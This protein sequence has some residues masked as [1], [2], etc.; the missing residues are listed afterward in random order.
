M[1]QVATAKATET[2]AST[3]WTTLKPV[4]RL[5]SPTMFQMRVPQTQRVQSEKDRRMMREV[6]LTP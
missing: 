4:D 6:R 5:S 3:M 1:I 2:A